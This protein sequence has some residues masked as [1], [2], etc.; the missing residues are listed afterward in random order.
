MRAGAG[1]TGCGGNAGWHPAP[2][3]GR[4]HHYT[5]PPVRFNRTGYLA[6]SVGGTGTRW[7][8]VRRSPRHL[9]AF[10]AACIAVR[11][12]ESRERVAEERGEGMLYQT[13]LSLPPKNCSGDRSN[14][15]VYPYFPWAGHRWW[16]SARSRTSCAKRWHKGGFTC[17]RQP[18]RRSGRYRGQ[19]NVLATALVAAILAIKDT[20]RIIPM[21]HA[22]LLGAITVDFA[23][24]DGFIEAVVRITTGKD[25]G[26]DG[27]ADGRSV[28]PCHDLGHG[29][30][31]GKRYERPIPVTPD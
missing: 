22:I 9:P 30:V 17:G 21:C 26:G 31:R 19:G 29:Q 10:E 27:S 8:G 3:R 14:G 7:Q 2:Q 13:W 18:L 25:R 4:G 16:I 11:N 24:G 6:M 5:Q 12:R 1:G 15:R 28:A 20:P 23:E